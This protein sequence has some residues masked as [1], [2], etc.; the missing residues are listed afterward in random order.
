MTPLTHN[1]A[2]IYHPKIV[3]NQCASI[4]IIQS[5]EDVQIVTAKNTIKMADVVIAFL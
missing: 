4:D 1:P 5:H 2:K 3:L